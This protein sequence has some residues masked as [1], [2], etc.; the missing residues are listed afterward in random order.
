MSLNETAVGGFQ[1]W[2]FIERS[3]MLWLDIALP[4]LNI[5]HL[6]VWGTNY[7]EA[8]FLGYFV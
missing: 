6:G 5:S 7:L 1:L 4:S 2:A 8:V 3:L